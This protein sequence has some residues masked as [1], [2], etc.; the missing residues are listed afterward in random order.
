MKLRSIPGSSPPSA[1]DIETLTRKHETLKLCIEAFPGKQSIALQIVEIVRLDYLDTL[2][3]RFISLFFTVSHSPMNCKHGAFLLVASL[4]SL[5]LNSGP[6]CVIY[7]KFRP[8]PCAF[9]QAK[10]TLWL[11]KKARLQIRASAGENGDTANWSKWVPTSA[12]AADKV[13]RLIAGAAASPIGQYIASPTTFLHSV[14]P[15]V[16]LVSDFE[17]N[18]SILSIGSS[19]LVL[20]Q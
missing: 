5:P 15:R 11:V 18:S 20:W 3:L 19:I 1:A 10:T 8:T 2:Y 4:P 7:P 16:K 14:D 9:L 13:L 6:R 17:I 12:L